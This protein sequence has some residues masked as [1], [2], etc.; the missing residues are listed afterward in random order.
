[1]EK[2]DIHMDSYE[3]YMKMEREN[4]H[5]KLTLAERRRKEKDFGKM[6]KQHK[7]KLK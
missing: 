1:V 7:K 4:E 6:L 5:F 2:G 3:N